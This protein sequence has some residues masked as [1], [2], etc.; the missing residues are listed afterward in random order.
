MDVDTIMQ[1]AMV[2]VGLKN[3][4]TTHEDRARNY[5]N[6]ALAEWATLVPWIPTIND[7]LTFNTVA[8]T[9]QYSLDAS[10][11]ELVSMRDTTNDRPLRI[12]DAETLN[13]MDPDASEEADPFWAALVGKNATTGVFVVDLAPTPDAIVTIEYTAHVYPTELTSSEDTDELD[14]YI[15]RNYH[16]AIIHA[17]AALFAGERGDLELEQTENGH[18]E[19]LYQRALMRNNPLG[20]Q[21]MRWGG[22]GGD[23]DVLDP[24]APDGVITG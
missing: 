18:K 14:I 17:I 1:L 20:Q 11:I 5:L 16:Q 22:A 13:R 2:R 3:T 4:N 6:L 23:R 8:S 19:R 15:P 9:R 10:V 21:P 7:A 12:V 24:M